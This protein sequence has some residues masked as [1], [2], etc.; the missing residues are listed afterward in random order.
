MKKG[1]LLFLLMALCGCKESTQSGG[2][3]L[4]GTW[5]A[6]VE[7]QNCAPADLCASFGFQQGLIVTAV[8]ELD[9][10]GNDVSGTYTYQGL[11]IRADV[12]GILSGTNL[13]LNGSINDPLGTATVELTGTV[14]GDAINASI[15]HRITATDGRAATASG[16]GTF[17]R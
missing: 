2:I 16:S 14:S 15:S 6:Q 8:M 13:A 10:D 7:I 5:T 11:P 17:T 4:D 3:D 12:D 9:Q 1:F